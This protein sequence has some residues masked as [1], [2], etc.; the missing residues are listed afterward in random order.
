MTE[1]GPAAAGRTVGAPSRDADV[2]GL[3]DG[4]QDPLVHPHRGGPRRTG[5]YRSCDGCGDR[6][7]ARPSEDR[8]GH[9]R[10]FCSRACQLASY[11]G[12]GNPN[13]RGGRYVAP[14]GYV[15]V[16]VGRDHPQADKHGYYEEHRYVMEQYLGRILDPAECVHHRNHRRDDNSI[17]NLELM[18]SWAEHQRHHAYYETTACPECGAPVERSRG[19]RR[20]WRRA[21]CSVKCSAAAGSRAAREGGRLTGN[22][23]LTAEQA[24]AIRERRAAGE[25][26]V[27]LAEEYGVSVD[28]VRRIAGGK[29]W[30][31]A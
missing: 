6:F 23:K 30:V 3:I 12:A 5:E 2:R 15:Y 25:K 19:Q 11:R 27:R 16:L 29:A 18:G 13:W 20:R 22:P 10:R 17:E 28:Q 1:L 26:V 4:V 31:A 9:R 24:R 8:R 21:F 14:S 7:Y